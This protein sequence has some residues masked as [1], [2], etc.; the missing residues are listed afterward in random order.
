MYYIDK[1]KE[2]QKIEACHHIFPREPRPKCTECGVGFGYVEKNKKPRI[3]L[4]EQK[5]LREYEIKKG[6]KPRTV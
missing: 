1:L 3:I 6:N 5:A 2:I 4:M